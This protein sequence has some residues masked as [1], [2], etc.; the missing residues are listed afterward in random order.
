[1]VK[2]DKYYPWTP[3]WVILSD[4]VK[5]STLAWLTCLHGSI[6]VCSFMKL[7]LVQFWCKTTQMKAYN[8]FYKNILPLEAYEAPKISKTCPQL[9]PSPMWPIAH[10]ALHP[11]S[12]WIYVL[13]CHCA[14]LP[15][16]LIPM[17]PITYMPH[18]SCCPSRSMHYYANVH[19][20]PSAPLPMC[21]INHVPHLPCLP[22]KSMHY[23]I[24][25]P[26]THLAPPMC[27]NVKRCQFVK[28]MLNV[29]KSNTWT[30]EEVHKE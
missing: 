17:C 27:Q 25:V 21:P 9:A 16:C 18:H 5:I 28:E 23:Y 8:V 3:K 29:K 19:Q 12:I 14:P 2:L 26:I 1:M 20:H 7:I 30:M 15:M 22:S 10:V 13:L 24:H 11:V 4:L 6:T